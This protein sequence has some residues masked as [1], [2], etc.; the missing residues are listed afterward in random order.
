MYWKNKSILITGASGFVGSHLTKRLTREGAKIIILNRVKE[1]LHN[2]ADTDFVNGL[3]KKNHFNFCFHLAGQPLVDVASADPTPT[4]EVNI[5]GTWNVLEA[6]RNNYLEAVV[7]ASTSHVY[8][9]SK[10]PFVEEYFPK[11]SRPY[12][13]SKACADLIAQTYAS[14]Y[15]MPIAIARFVN[16]YG[17]GDKNARLIPRTIQ[18]L[19]QNKDP[20][21]FQSQTTRDYMYIDDAVDAYL[22][23][24]QKMSSNKKV[25]SNVIFNFGTGKHYTNTEVVKKI[26]QLFG[27]KYNSH[28]IVDINRPQEISKQ[29]VSIEKAKNILNWQPNFSLN[30]GLKK[31]IDWYSNTLK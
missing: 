19:L 15:S 27:R 16:I 28:F 24:A 4:F 10:L 11:P 30:D 3:F 12:E 29:Y 1:V 7:I 18:L 13:T 20:E 23:L 8:G 5:K 14:Y 2:I 31:T 17:P 25:D 21:I 9:N 26:L 22:L 6:A